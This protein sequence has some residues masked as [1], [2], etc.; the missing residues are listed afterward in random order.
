ASKKWEKKRNRNSS[1]IK[2]FK[3]WLVL[4]CPLETREIHELPPKE[5]DDYLASFY[6]S[7]KRQNGTDFSA[8]SL[9]FFQKSIERHLRDHDYEYSV[10]KGLEFRASQEALKV[11]QQQ[12]SQKEREAEWSLL[13]NLMDKDVET[14]RRKGLVSQMHPQGLLHLMFTNIVR[15]FGA[16]THHQSHNLCWGQLVLG[17]DEGELEYLEWKDDPSAEVNPGAAGPYLFA[18]PDTPES[19]P[20]AGYKEYARRRPADMLHDHDPLYLA[21]KPLCSIWDQVWYCRKALAKAKME[22]ILKVI[23]Q[24]VKGPVKGS[25]K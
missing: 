1:D 4:H 7:A 17:S 13:E 18:K 12:L 5:L 15:G 21:P 2:V 20:V 6:S 9:H 19:C 10:V 24:H 14:L 23:V 25:K 8:N 3:D 16:R 11:K 22:K